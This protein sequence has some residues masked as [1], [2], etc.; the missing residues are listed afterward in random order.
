MNVEITNVVTTITTWIGNLSSMNQQR[1]SAIVVAVCF[2]IVIIL[3]YNIGLS[4]KDLL[5]S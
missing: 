1:L 2:T 3:V 5:E 4:I